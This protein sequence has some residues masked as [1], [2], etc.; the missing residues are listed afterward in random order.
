MPHKR[1][2][3][4]ILPSTVDFHL[5]NVRERLLLLSDEILKV[6]LLVSTG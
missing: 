5:L 4:S 1:G 3:G 2:A 6:L